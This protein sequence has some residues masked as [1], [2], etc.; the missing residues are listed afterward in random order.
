MGRMSGSQNRD[1]EPED[2]S[3]G[4][5]SV[6]AVMTGMGETGV[7]EFEGNATASSVSYQRG[8]Q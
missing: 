7:V 3:V 8:L 4:S 2:V 1:R 6:A 5:E